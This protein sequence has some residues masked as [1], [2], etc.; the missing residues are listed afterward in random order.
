MKNKD[1]KKQRVIRKKIAYIIT[2]IILLVLSFLIILGNG[3]T[4]SHVEITMK[5]V[6]VANGDTLWEIAETEAKNNMYYYEKDIRYIIKDIKEVN[7][8]VN[9][10]LS[11]GQELFV[12]SL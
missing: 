12:P 8:L 5:K 7:H 6:F 2:I 10:N 3:K 1:D 11:I 4:S 9:S